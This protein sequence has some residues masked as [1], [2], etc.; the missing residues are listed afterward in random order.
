[1]THDEQR[2]FATPVF[3]ALASAIFVVLLLSE[4]TGLESAQLGSTVR[5]TSRHA[6]LAAGIRALA[7]TLGLRGSI[8]VAGVVLVAMT[9]WVGLTY[10]R[11]TR[12]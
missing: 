7:E 4:A 11:I 8:G 12:G 6:A 5:F 2:R 9:L 3:F 1:M 10:R